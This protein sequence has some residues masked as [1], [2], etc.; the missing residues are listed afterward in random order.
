MAGARATEAMMEL[1][2][3]LLSWNWGATRTPEDFRPHH[4]AA[5]GRNFDVRRGIPVSTGALP[6]VLAGCSCAWGPPMP[7]ASVLV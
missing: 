4:K 6:G 5:D 7:G 1:Y 3:P 2:G